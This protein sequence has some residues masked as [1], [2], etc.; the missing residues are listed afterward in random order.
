MKLG[1]WLCERALYVCALASTRHAR[2][3]R[4]TLHK[5]G[6]GGAALVAACC[7]LCRVAARRGRAVAEAHCELDSAVA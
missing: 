3:L 4:P 5:A 6:T 7:S 2:L 1:T